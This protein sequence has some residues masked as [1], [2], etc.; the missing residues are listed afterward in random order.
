[1][2]VGVSG[3]PLYSQLPQPLER[4]QNPFNLLGAFFVLAAEE[5]GEDIGVIRSG[6]TLVAGSDELAEEGDLVGETVGPGRSCELQVFSF[7]GRG[8][9]SGEGLLGC[10]RRAWRPVIAATLIVRAQP[11]DDAAL[12]FGGALV[13]EGDKAGEQ[14]VF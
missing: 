4:L 6:D 10:L 13:V 14:R 11:A 1:M 7:Q 9:C 3:C 5:G 2:I 12:F 8:F